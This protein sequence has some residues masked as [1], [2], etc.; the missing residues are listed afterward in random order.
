MKRWICALSFRQKKWFLVGG[1]LTVL[2]IGYYFISYASIVPREPLV[3]LQVDKAIPFWPWTVWIYLIGLYLPIPYIIEKARRPEILVTALLA[4][5]CTG[6]IAFAFFWLVPMAYPRPSVIPG[7]GLSSQLLTWVY[8][9]DSPINTFP[10]L[11]VGYSTIFYLIIR[12]EVPSQRL[13]FFVN[14]C[15]ILASTLT[16]KQHFLLDG[17]AGILLALLSF[18]AAKALV[19]RPRFAKLSL[20]FA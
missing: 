13:F 9:V 10:S 20:L 2:I 8:L 4:T 17:I 7:G 1:G 12:E 14:L 16:T 18:R 5:L 3:Q 6:F 15:L 11:H 19:A